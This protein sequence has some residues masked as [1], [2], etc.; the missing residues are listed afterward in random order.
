MSM[1]RKER[2]I[3][4]YQPSYTAMLTQ[5]ATEVARLRINGGDVWRYAKALDT[6]LSIMPFE[7]KRRVKEKVRRQIGVNGVTPTIY[8][9]ATMIF[10]ECLESINRDKPR[11]YW[12]DKEEACLSEVEVA[13]DSFFDI[14]FTEADMLGL[15]LIVQGVQVGGEMAVQE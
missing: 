11:S 1:P 3:K 4:G 6:L 5:V 10:N 2:F 9:V 8:E 15:W 14:M 7:V 13:L 12:K